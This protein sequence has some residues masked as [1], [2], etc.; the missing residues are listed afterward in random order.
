M[1]CRDAGSHVSA[2]LNG[3]PSLSHALPAQYATKLQFYAFLTSNL[4]LVAHSILTYLLTEDFR[5]SDLGFAQGLPESTSITAT[6]ASNWQL[7]SL[8]LTSR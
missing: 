6:P 1:S 5:V 8:L 2:H 7:S 3:N 4:S